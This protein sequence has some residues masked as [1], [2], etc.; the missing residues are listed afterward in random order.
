MKNGV[1]LPGETNSSLSIQN[2]GN[3]FNDANITVRVSNDFGSVISKPANLKLNSVSNSWEKIWLNSAPTNYNSVFEDSKGDIVLHLL[4]MP[5]GNLEFLKLDPNGNTIF[6]KDINSSNYSV[7][8]IIECKDGYFRLGTIDGNETF[9]RSQNSRGKQDYFLEKLDYNGNRIW[10]KTYGAENNDLAFGIIKGPNNNY[11]IYGKSDSNNTSVGEKSENSIGRTDIWLVLIDESGNKIWDKTIGSDI[12]DS[13]FFADSN[14]EGYFLTAKVGNE[15]GLFY[16]DASNPQTTYHP[17]DT[18][19]EEQN[20]FGQQG[21][22]CITNTGSVLGLARQDMNNTHILSIESSGVVRSIHILP[23]GDNNRSIL[24]HR[25]IYDSKKDEVV[26][27]R[28]LGPQNN[29]PAEIEILRIGSSL[30]LISTK[31]L[32]LRLADLV[33]LFP[34]FDIVAIYIL[35]FNFLRDGS[36]IL[37]YYIWHYNYSENRHTYKLLKLNENG[38]LDVSASP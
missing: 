34:N 36:I 24:N 1:E 37:G 19:S 17:F 38:I 7:M 27:A 23:I 5:S 8:D 2:I 12:E 31:R 22:F 35:D 10:D 4:E 15:V 3:N 11:L 28:L 33:E 18:Y 6:S 16:I 29:L 9:Q 20:N 32:P 30:N 21:S 26:I 14:D 25:I 13:T